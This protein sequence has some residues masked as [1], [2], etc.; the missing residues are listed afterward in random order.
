MKAFMDSMQ[1]QVQVKIEPQKYLL[2]AKTSKT[3]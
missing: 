1:A 3:Y 2:Q